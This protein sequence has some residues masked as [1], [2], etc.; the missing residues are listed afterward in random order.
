MS[1]TVNKYIKVLWSTIGNTLASEQVYC[2]IYCK[3][4]SCK[5]RIKWFIY[6]KLCVLWPWM[7]GFLLEVMRAAFWNCCHSYVN[8]NY[9]ANVL[10]NDEIPTK[11]NLRS[12]DGTLDYALLL[13]H[14]WNS[15]ET[16]PSM[17]PTDFVPCNTILN[18][19]LLLH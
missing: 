15:Q 2:K 6:N 8:T 14:W 12:Y 11:R 5:G 16:K 17:I 9:C 19:K 13:P 10:F 18:A 4:V 1:M 7:S 3:R